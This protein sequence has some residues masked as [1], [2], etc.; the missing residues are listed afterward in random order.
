MV[1]WDFWTN[2]HF[3]GK[4][5][6][7]LVTLDIDEASVGVIRVVLR[8][9]GAVRGVDCKCGEENGAIAENGDHLWL[10]QARSARNGVQCDRRNPYHWWMSPNLLCPGGLICPG[11]SD[12]RWRV[13]VDCLCCLTIVFL[14]V[15]CN[16]ACRYQCLLSFQEQYTLKYPLYIFFAA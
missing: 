11:Q 1:S 6:P 7:R 4:D 14:Y 16:Q 12:I 10:D 13:Q 8:H 2:L 9:Y 5:D 15:L 3:L